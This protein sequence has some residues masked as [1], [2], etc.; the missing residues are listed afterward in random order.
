MHLQGKKH[1]IQIPTMYLKP[2]NNIY[3]NTDKNW[4]GILTVRQFLKNGDESNSVKNEKNPKNFEVVDIWLS[5]KLYL[6]LII[7]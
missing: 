5:N 2:I 4:S 6:I 3:S 7:F 1:S